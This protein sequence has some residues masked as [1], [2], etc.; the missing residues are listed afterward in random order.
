MSAPTAAAAARH[1][2]DSR[3]LAGLAAGVAAGAV[4]AAAPSGRAA[5]LGT[6]V[7][8][9]VVVGARSWQKP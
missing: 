1:P 6:A 4:L 3:V 8:L 7:A 5:P 9:A 2:P